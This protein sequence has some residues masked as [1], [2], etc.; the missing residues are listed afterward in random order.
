[1][2]IGADGHVLIADFGL[3]KPNIDN[4]TLSYSF[5]GSPEYMAP[6]MLT[7]AGHSFTIDYYCVGALLYELVTG[8]PPYYSKDHDEI[9]NSILNEE[10][11]FPSYVELSSDIKS[12]LRGLLDKNPK[13][14]LGSYKGVAEI[15]IHP[16]IGR[17]NKAD[18]VAK[19]LKPPFVPDPYSFNFDQ[20]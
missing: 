12:L 18:I 5:C 9:Y 20:N 11:T 19:K 6:E 1:L 14:R 17:L 10:L 8:L 15:F 16:W 3:A 2:L 7:R 4:K 13:S